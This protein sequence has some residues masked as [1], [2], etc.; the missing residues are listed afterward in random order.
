MK[1]G[2]RDKIVF[3]EDIYSGAILPDVFQNLREGGQ[4][5]VWVIFIQRI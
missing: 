5:V 1:V 3:V 4:K 2:E